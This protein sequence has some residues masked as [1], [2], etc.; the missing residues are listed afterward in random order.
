MWGQIAAMAASGIGGLI[1]GFSGASGMRKHRNNM[2]GMYDALGAGQSYNFGLA[3]L[4]QQKTLDRIKEGGIAAA[5]GIQR[6]GTLAK[7]SAVDQG[8]VTM[9]NANVSATRRGLYNTT[10]LDANR[11]AATSDTQNNLDMIEMGTGSAMASLEERQAQAEAQG[12]SMLA[13]LQMQRNAAEMNL[14]LQ[15]I[16]TYGQNY[17]PNGGQIIGGTLANLGGQA[18]GLMGM[19]GGGGGGSTF[20]SLGYSPGSSVQPGTGY[21]P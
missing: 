1:G 2:M 5:K 13:Q 3:E 16:D 17:V 9:G 19:G 6:Y 20:G 14:G 11:R 10:V 8:K 21:M 15:R 4:Y 7:R 18:M 12:M